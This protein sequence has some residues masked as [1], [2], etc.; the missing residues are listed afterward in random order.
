[1]LN[2][3]AQS[4]NKLL[5]SI[6]LRLVR[7]RNHALNMRKLDE[8]QSLRFTETR[9]G[10]LFDFLQHVSNSKEIQKYLSLSKG[11]LLQDLF[12]L[13]QNSWKRSGFFVEFGATDGIN[14][15]NTFLLEKE[16]GWT[17]ILAEPGRNWHSSLEKNRTAKISKECVW[18]ESGK[19]LTFIES[20]FPEFSTIDEFQN[21]DGMATSRTPAAKY[22]VK[23]I[24]LKE[25][26]EIN[27]APNYI[28]YISI[29]TEGSELDILTNFPF[30]EYKFG[31]LTVEH[32]HS[33]NETA[34]DNLLSEHGYERVHRHTSQF[35]GWYVNESPRK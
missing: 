2:K 6:N 16:F 23:T 10:F 35:D 21:M 14:L 13:E 5:S 34:I 28:D 31:I 17:G 4:F 29:D 15:S 8:L 32:N 19:Y 18:R 25:L 12:V 20:E 30:S 27:N 22:Q 26:L 3:L 33:E 1:M 9:N 11:Q 24:T 7:E